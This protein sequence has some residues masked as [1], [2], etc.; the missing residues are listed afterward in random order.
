MLITVIIYNLTTI[1]GFVPDDIETLTGRNVVWEHTINKWSQNKIFGVN[2]ELWNA[3][4]LAEFYS[5]YNWTPNQ[6]HNQFFQTLGYAGIVGILALM[7][8][9]FTSGKQLMKNSK[10]L[11]SVVNWLLICIFVRSITETPLTPDIYNEGFTIQFIIL[12]CLAA[13]TNTEKTV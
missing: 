10:N 7:L 1:L 13:R 9:Y 4:S 8:F 3:Q 11:N 2:M 6:S 5:L 12:I